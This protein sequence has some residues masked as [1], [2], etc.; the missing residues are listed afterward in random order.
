MCH[1]NPDARFRVLESVQIGE[2]CVLYFLIPFPPFP[3][4]LHSLPF[5]L[6]FPLVVHSHDVALAPLDHTSLYA[7]AVVYRRAQPVSSN[8]LDAFWTRDRCGKRFR[9]HGLALH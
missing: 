6:Y 2:P 4:P 9:S 3:P 1:R 8:V 7:L 5:I